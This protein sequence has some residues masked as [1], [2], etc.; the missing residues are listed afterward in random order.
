MTEATVW[1]LV[2]VDTKAMQLQCKRMR[3]CSANETNKI[4]KARHGQ[5]QSETTISQVTIDNNSMQINGN[6][7]SNETNKACC[8]KARAKWKW[9][10]KEK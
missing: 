7:G 3:N 1:I 5:K 10:W 6:S 2:D 4:Q 8:K 9:K